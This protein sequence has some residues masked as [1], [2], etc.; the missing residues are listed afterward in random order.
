[1]GDV[2]GR[3]D[4]GEDVADQAGNSVDGKGVEGVVNVAEE[5]DLGAV[6]GQPGSEDT[7]RDGCPDGDVS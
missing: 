3:K 7:E 2:F 5:L 4:A 6:V 1:M